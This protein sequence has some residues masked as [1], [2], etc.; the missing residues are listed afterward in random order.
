MTKVLNVDLALTIMWALKQALLP[1]KRSS[2]MTRARVNAADLSAFPAL[3]RP[4]RAQAPTQLLPHRPEA[5]RGLA[6]LP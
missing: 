2:A 3:A 5:P 4:G 1:E 6:R